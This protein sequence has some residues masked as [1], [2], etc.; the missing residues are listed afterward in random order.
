M[1]SDVAKPVVIIGGGLAGLTCARELHRAGRP[2]VL[3]E[4][5]NDIGGRIR[6]DIVDGFRLDRGFQV[7]LTAYPAAQEQFDYSKLNLRSYENGALVRRDGT[8][9][10]FVDPW[11][12]PV[13]GAKSV[14]G[15]IG[16]FFDK[17]RVAKLRSRSRSGTVA[18]I[19]N[20]PETTTA[21]CLHELGFSDDMIDAF[22]RPFLGGVFLERELKTSSRVLHFVFRMFSEGDVAVPALGM[23][24]LPRQI[25]D[26]IPADQIRCQVAARTCNATSVTTYDGETIEAAN[27]VVATSRNAAARLLQHETPPASRRVRCLYFAA[28]RPPVS[29]PILLLNGDGVGPINNLCVPSLVSPD[30]APPGQHLISVS[31]VEPSFVESKELKSLVMDQCGEWFG[32]AEV[33]SWSF[34]AEYDIPHALP[35]QL[36]GGEVGCGRAIVRDGVVICGDHVGNASIQ[37]ALESGLDAATLLASD[38]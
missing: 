2:F 14:F 8:F 24:Q 36:S 27:V 20:R 34:L 29:E 37:S 25:A 33:A 11:R 31:V 30:Y 21:D 28:E 18:E 32:A 23:Q 22:F 6:T 10:R 16:S 26:D 7:L 17:L 5:S 9:H 15:P 38:V 4:A 12:N 13:A 35:D 1:N 19:F 3:L